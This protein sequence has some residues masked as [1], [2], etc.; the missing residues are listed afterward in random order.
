M[1]T[2]VG[3]MYVDLK[4]NIKNLEKGVKQS[5]KELQKISKNTKKTN[6]EFQL[7]NNNMVRSIRRLETVAVAA[8]GVYHAFDKLIY[9]GVRLNQQYEDQAIGIAALTSAK[10]KFIDVSGKELNAYESFLAAQQLTASTMDDIKKA[11]L[12]TP[13]SF[14][15]MIG[16]YQ[17]TI[18]HAITENNTFGK[19]MEEVN[20]N[21]ITF[22]QRMSALG[23][24][25]GMEMPKINEE[26]RSLMSGN[27]STDSLLAMMLF[28]SPTEANEAVREAKK[29]TDGLS[30]LLLD[31]LKPFEQVQGVMTYTKALAQMNA[32]FDD[33]KRNSMNTF[34]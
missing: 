16:F 7:F 13:A 25:A 21:V 19:S 6:K 2:N 1:A 32:A 3:D 34:I 23:S 10:T 24:A 30:T 27:A 8:L 29:R 4:L 26:I 5:Q 18:G 22:T 15:Q 14:Q 12:D 33:I 17:Q 20:D 11:A 31:A 9:A 28:G